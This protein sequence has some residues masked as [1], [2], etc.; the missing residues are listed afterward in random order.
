[1][2]ADESGNDPENVVG[3]DDIMA[4]LGDWIEQLP[5]RHQEILARRFGLN[6]YDPATLEEVGSEVGL[7]RERVRQ[8]QIEALNK[9]KRIISREG[10]SMD[11][12]L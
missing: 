10:L 9:L 8:L 3:G 12:V 2:V 7:T 5:E 1:M 4:N 11:G 6:G